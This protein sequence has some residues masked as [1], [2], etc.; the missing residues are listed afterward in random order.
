MSQERQ[1]RVCGCTDDDCSD[2]IE[3]TGYPCEWVED[4]LC[5]ACTG[6]GLIHYE[7]LRQVDAE[8]Y[9]AAG[10]D[11]HTGHELA[12]AAACY[13]RH[14]AYPRPR[15]MADVPDPIPVDWPVGWDKRMWKPSPGD[16]IRDLTK[17]GALIAAEIDRLLRIK[18]RERAARGGGE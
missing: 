1:C 11:L 5:S 6:I 18:E 17:A 14:A 10:D 15:Y 16:P 4:D 13:V 8:I 2:C 7:R 12:Q 9:T 3:R